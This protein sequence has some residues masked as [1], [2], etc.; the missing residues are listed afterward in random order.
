LRERGLQMSTYRGS[1]LIHDFQKTATLEKR[2][3]RFIG[4]RN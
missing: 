1:G 2:C 3:R 4:S